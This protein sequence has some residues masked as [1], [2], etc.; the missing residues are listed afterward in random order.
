MQTNKDISWEM[1]KEA[2]WKVKLFEDKIKDN[3]TR[4]EL[5]ELLYSYLTVIS[6][7][8]DSI[9]C[10]HPTSMKK[11]S[12]SIINKYQNRIAKENVKSK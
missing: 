1:Y 8:I 3:Y 12:K 9:D 6:Y 2:L 5:E 11:L 10:E 4:S 7:D